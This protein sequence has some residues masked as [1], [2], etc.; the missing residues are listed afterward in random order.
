MARGIALAAAV[1]GALFWAFLAILPPAPRDAD[2][3]ATDFSAT[4][5]FADIEAIGRE[6][7]PSARRAMRGS[8]PI[9]PA[10]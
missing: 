1:A 3:P 8:G 9:S 7:H 4:R 10:A 5:A 6:P 2:T